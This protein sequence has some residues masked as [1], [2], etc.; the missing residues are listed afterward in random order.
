MK[1]GDRVRLVNDPGTL[2][3]REVVGTI[4]KVYTYDEG[5]MAY[6]TLEDGRSIGI[7][8]DELELVPADEAQA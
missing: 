8:T 2:G 4:T 6:V 5:R 7:N 3:V 1:V